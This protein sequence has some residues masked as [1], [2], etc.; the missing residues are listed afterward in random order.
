[1]ATSRGWRIAWA[2]AVT[3]T[4]GYGILFYAYGVFT[5]PMERE[6]GLTRD[7][8]SLAFAAALLVSGLAALPAGRIVDRYGGR[9]LMTLGSLAGGA[10]LVAWSR[11]ETFAGLV[12][13]QA[14]IGL[15]LAA[16]TYEVA[17]AVLVPWFRRDR[18]RALL[19]VTF[20]AGFA[21]TIF[22]PLAT[23]LEAWLGWRAALATLGATLW[24][25]TVP[26]HAFVV[27]RAP[28]YGAGDRPAREEEPVADAGGDADPTAESDV[29][30]G[31]AVRTASFWWWTLGF[32]VDR[33]VI[34]AVAAHAVPLLLEAGHG[35]ERTAALVGS[36]GAF[37]VAGR[38]AFA[39]LA[40]RLP[41]GTATVAT[42]ALR[43]AALAT[44]A[45]SLAASGPAVL[46]L[47]WAFAAAFGLANGAS[48]LAR[49]GLI[50]ERYGPRRYGTVSGAM[51]T[52]AAFV[53]PAAPLV[54]GAVRVAQDGYF[55]AVLVL[56][57]AAALAALA[58]ALGN[59]G[60]RH[61]T[62]KGGGTR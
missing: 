42:F 25:A 39:P 46:V 60:A 28:A 1:M 19:L 43:T 37:Q 7:R 61:G 17:F 26:L 23:A 58:I 20:A 31:R 21:S 6:L 32:A 55:A 15:V 4:V 22:V 27:R 50:A 24:I 2:L 16:V 56:V 48:T 18:L 11:V 45:A 40:E 53:Q 29:G 33:G 59:A 13:T 44:L 3:Q 30:L 54:L 49:A 62:P 35:P 12:A 38:V 51:T 47:L 5:V 9:A 8:T 36:I 10:A 57:G 34:V 41:I 52:T 14:V